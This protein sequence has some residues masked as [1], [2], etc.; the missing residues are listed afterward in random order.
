MLKCMP[1][2]TAR[3]IRGSFGLTGTPLPTCVTDAKGQSCDEVKLRVSEEWS[4]PSRRSSPVGT[5]A[6]GQSQ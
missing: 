5:S 4:P 6:R 3:E 1:L 2:F